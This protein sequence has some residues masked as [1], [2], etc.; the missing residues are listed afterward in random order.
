MERRQFF[1]GSAALLVGCATQSASNGHPGGVLAADTAEVEPELEG[2]PDLWMGY[3]QDALR[4]DKNENP[5]GPSP[6]AIQAAEAALEH[7]NRYVNP[8]EL[9]TRL[10]AHHGVEPRTIQLGTGS[11]E[12]LRMVPLAFMQPGTNLVS[13]TEGYRGAPDGARFLGH[14]V[15]YVPLTQDWRY[16]IPAMLA[17]IDEHTRV[18][19]L[20]NPNNPTGTLLTRP[21]IHEVA[22]ALPPEAVLLVDEAYFEFLPRGETTAIEL[23]GTLPNLMVLRTFS[24]AYGLAGLRLGYAV[25]QPR[26]I[27]RL[28][29]AMSTWTNVAAYAA[30]SAALE[31]QAH[32]RRFTEHAERCRVFYRE[33]LGALGLPHQIGHAP[34]LLVKLGADKVQPAL[35]ALA[36]QGIFVRDG[37]SWDLPDWIRISFG[38]DEANARV[39][40]QLRAWA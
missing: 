15:R 14:E 36:G 19:S 13:P 22:K 25:A 37:S 20:V 28:A 6:K 35:Q 9:I 1:L 18:F 38:L 39:I 30:A 31:D 40:E 34:L 26:L 8:R 33:Q 10:A 21:E 23:V 5:F 17:A 27:E 32:V 7:A 11:G 16:D 2:L 3:G 4:L 24:K 29:P 12:I